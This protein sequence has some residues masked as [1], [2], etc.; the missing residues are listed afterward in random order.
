MGNCL[1]TKLKGVVNNDNLPHLGRFLV[2]IG[3]WSEGA[4]SSLNYN[5]KLTVWYTKVINPCAYLLDKDKEVI[6]ARSN[7]NS[8]FSTEYIYPAPGDNPEKKYLDFYNKY[9]IR[10]IANLMM[11]SNT[12]TPYK[13]DFDDLISLPKLEHFRLSGSHIKGTILSVIEKG[14]N[15][16]NWTGFALVATNVTGTLA[17]Y[18]SLSH[19]PNIINFSGTPVTG[20]IES[21]V[22]AIFV[23]HNS[24]SG[25]T[26]ISE[27][28][29]EN[30]T[31]NGG[32]LT[33][34]NIVFDGSSATVKNSSNV[35]LGTYNGTTWTYA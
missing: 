8:S 18:A 28:Y 33:D 20:T 22:E 15:S 11:R 31:F 23:K 34:G 19:I 17:D 30:N 5:R 3:P 29:N 9:E 4:T 7:N 16:N 35:V 1:V 25:T 26:Q 27:N 2:T 32:R 6:E 12:E 10:I 24:P 14:T 13:Y 21:Y